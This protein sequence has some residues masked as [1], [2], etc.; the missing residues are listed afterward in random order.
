MFSALSIDRRSR[1]SVSDQM[2]HY[3]IDEILSL[4]VHAQT[5]FP[6][7]KTVA[8]QFNV[9]TSEVEE[10]YARLVAESYCEVQGD[11]ITLIE[12]EVRR[13]I[14]ISSISDVLDIALTMNMIA[15]SQSFKP[16]IG[17]LPP[18]LL[19]LSKQ[20]MSKTS[21][22]LQS[23]NFGDEIPLSYVMVI[24]NPKKITNQLRSLASN[25]DFYLTLSNQPDMIV[26]PT[27]MSACRLSQ[28]ISSLLRLSNNTPAICLHSSIDSLTQTNI[29]QM[30][31]MLTPRVFLSL[32]T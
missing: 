3:V 32:K 20:R 1:H 23:L 15:T 11:T 4:N 8:L 31:V 24:I 16:V 6:E 21:I 9:D 14:Q 17:M 25:T 2:Y 13:S 22:L 26:Q 29:A 19:G 28:D 27:L 7:S 10:A 5:I 18:E 12:A 30:Y